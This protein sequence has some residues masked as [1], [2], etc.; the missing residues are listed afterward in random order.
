MLKCNCFIYT[1]SYTNV[2]KETAVYTE[3]YLVTQTTVL[4]AIQNCPFTAHLSE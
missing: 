3:S 1:V 2:I 4:I